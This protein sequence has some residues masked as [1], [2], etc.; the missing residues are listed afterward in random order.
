MFHDKVRIN[1]Y[2]LKFP[3]QQFKKNFVLCILYFFMFICRGLS[4]KV[5]KVSS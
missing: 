1:I 3:S 5:S 4:K 2:P